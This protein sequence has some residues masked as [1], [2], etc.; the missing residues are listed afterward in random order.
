[1]STSTAA[2]ATEFTNANLETMYT[3]GQIAERVRELGAE[4]TAAYA[5]KDL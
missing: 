5:G 4:I 3:A 2:V 1:M